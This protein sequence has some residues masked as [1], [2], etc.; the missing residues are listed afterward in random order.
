MTPSLQQPAQDA[1]PATTVTSQEAQRWPL[2]PWAQSIQDPV[3]KLTAPLMCVPASSLGPSRESQIRNQSQGLS[4]FSCV[5]AAPTRGTPDA[6][7]QPALKLSR[8][9]S[10][11]LGGSAGMQRRAADSL[12]VASSE[13]TALASLIWGAPFLPASAGSRRAG[14]L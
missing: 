7:P 5:P 9:P 12:A 1:H 6:F 2:Q 4:C 13:E 8:S 14:Q 10:A 3:N 11:C